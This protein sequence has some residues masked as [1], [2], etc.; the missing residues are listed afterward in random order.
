MQRV[1]LT[2]KVLY[3]AFMAVLVPYYWH[4]YTAWNFLYFCDV[5]LFLTLV[6][7]WTERPLLISIPAVGILLPQAIWVVDLLARAVAGVHLTGMTEYMFDPAIPLFVRS[8]SSFHGWLP[9]LLIWLLM[10]MGYDRRAILVQ[11]VL[12]VSLLVICYAWGPVGPAVGTEAVNVN[13]VFGMNDAAPQT[14]MAPVAW[15]ALMMAVNVV[16]FH[17]PT[18][19]LLTWFQRRGA[20]SLGRDAPVGS[21]LLQVGKGAAQHVR[22]AL[23]ALAFLRGHGRLE[24]SNAPRGSDHGRQ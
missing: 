6:G 5:A 18:H 10:R 14:S 4:E 24:H 1:P 23:D 3:A 22:G 8:L 7:I 19:A 17:L 12:A 9:F 11:P 16:L 2:A 20:V 15:L 13:Y 21:R